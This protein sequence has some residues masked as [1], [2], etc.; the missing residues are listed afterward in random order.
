MI[1][2]LSVSTIRSCATGSEG[3]TLLRQ[4]I[5]VGHALGFS[6]SPTWLANNKHKFSGIDPTTIQT[7]ICK[8]NPRL[9]GCKK[10]LSGREPR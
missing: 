10:E 8:H 1:A 5:K 2:D 3:K 9:K 4:D 6:A 7:N